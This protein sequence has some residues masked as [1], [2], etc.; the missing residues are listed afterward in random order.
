ME[1]SKLQTLKCRAYT[2]DGDDVMLAISGA[3]FQIHTILST[4]IATVWS[5]PCPSSP[6]LTRQAA[7]P[8]VLSAMVT[9]R[10]SPVKQLTRDISAL[11]SCQ[12]PALSVPQTH[13]ETGFSLL[14]FPGFCCDW[15]IFCSINVC[16]FPSLYFS[17][18]LSSS[19]PSYPLIL[20]SLTRK[21]SRSGVICCRRGDALLH[22]VTKEGSPEEQY[23]RINTKKE[24][25]WVLK[26]RRV[27]C[28]TPTWRRKQVLRPWGGS[29]LH[30]LKDKK[31]GQCDWVKEGRS[32]GWVLRSER[33]DLTASR[34]SSGLWLLFW[35]IQELKV[36]FKKITLTLC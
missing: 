17:F 8:V 28:A 32:E 4:V 34:P 16:L 10:I 2:R 6:N 35:E 18:S 9:W 22:R 5:L 14:S 33:P 12:P 1:E 26:I 7:C 24:R 11:E 31:G 27:L 15:M 20:S 23:W 25:E 30:M 3:D 36:K 19:S 29:W 13:H 21:K